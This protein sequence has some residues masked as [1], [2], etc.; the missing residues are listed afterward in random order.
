MRTELQPGIHERHCINEPTDRYGVKVIDVWASTVR[1]A[2]SDERV[3][4]LS[5]QYDDLNPDLLCHTINAN[6]IDIGRYRFVCVF[7][8]LQETSTTSRE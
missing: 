3:P 5:K 1:D 2:M 4:R 8:R 6:Q 7:E